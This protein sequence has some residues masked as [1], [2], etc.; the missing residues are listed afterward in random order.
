MIANAYRNLEFASFKLEL[1]PN[2]DYRMAL[3]WR[4]LH[5]I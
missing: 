4:A 2:K 1:D 3:Y 5:I